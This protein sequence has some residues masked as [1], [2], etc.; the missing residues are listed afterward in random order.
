MNTSII[1]IF[2]FLMEHNSKI[3]IMKFIALRFDLLK[4]IMKWLSTSDLIRLSKTCHIFFDFIN[5]YTQ[6]KIIYIN[7]CIRDDGLSYLLQDGDVEYLII[8]KCYRLSRFSFEILSRMNNL[9]CLYFD[10]CFLYESF[11]DE[12]YIS[13]KYIINEC[14]SVN[15]R[16]LRISMKYSRYIS[17]H[18]KIE[19]IELD[20]ENNT[21]TSYDID[22]FIN[23]YYIKRL[24]LRNMRV[25]TSNDTLQRD[26]EIE[27]NKL[28]Y[29]EMT[30][31][32]MQHDIDNL[33]YH[34]ASLKTLIIRCPKF[35]DMIV[36]NLIGYRINNLENLDL[37]N[38]NITDLIFSD[39]VFKSLYKIK[40]L[41]VLGCNHIT[42][43]A[44][45]FVKKSCLHLKRLEY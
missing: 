2:N 6:K 19:E 37:R 25:I 10:T 8:K 36:A 17:P 29:F 4:E 7:D 41:N 22:H 27:C 16:K 26:N 3:H 12:Q 40:T 14:L 1:L 28:E 32:S 38:T 30:N 23:R 33:K 43:K 35:D 18:H 20:G 9:R 34:Y 13:T 31:C 21:Y 42:H 24:V 11:F 45:A 44:I 39:N 5:L 15:L